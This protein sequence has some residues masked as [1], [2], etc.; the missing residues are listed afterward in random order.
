MALA[1][2]LRGHYGSACESFKALSGAQ[3]QVMRILFLASVLP[4]PKVVSGFIIVHHRISKLV[5][6]GYEVGLCC[7]VREDYEKFLPSIKPMLYEL[8]TFPT[9]SPKPSVKRM[10]NRMFSPMPPDFFYLDTDEMRK[11]IGRMIERSHYDLVIAEFT[12]MGHFLHHNPWLPPVR[13]I[14]SVHSCY[15]TMLQNS[16]DINRWSPSNLWKEML[17]PR[18]KRF[19]FDI[20]RSADHILALTPQERQNL[21]KHAPDLKTTTIPYGIDLDEFDGD[22]DHETD[23]SILITGYFRHLPNQDAVSWFCNEVWPLVRKLHPKLKLYI[24]GRQPPAYFRDLARKHPGI[25]VTGEVED[26]RPYLSKARIYICPMRLGSGLRGKILQAIAQGL[27]VV[28]TTH[29]AEGIPA[30]TGHNMMLADTP[31]IMANSIDLLLNEPELRKRLARNAKEIL[32]PMYSWDVCTDKLE[33]VIKEV[34]V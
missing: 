9:P 32:K 11:T 5:E 29:A 13:R 26:L 3:E 6:R 16:I 1:V 20:Y 22:P 2:N 12:V 24:V 33:K 31:A 34:V 27:P 7:F 4:H 8:E 19:E 14:V 21:L 18:L 17:L 10:V 28:S 25:I 23:E 15:T 30:Q